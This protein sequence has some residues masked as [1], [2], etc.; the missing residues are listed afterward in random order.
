M[1]TS[2]HILI[3]DDD[4]SVCWSLARFLDEFG[5]NI[6]AVESAEEGL[7]LMEDNSFDAGVIDLRL[8][9]ISGDAF[10]IEAHKKVP[11]MRFLIHTGSSDYELS[12]ELIDIGIRKEDVFI[13][14]LLDL[15][16][17]REALEKIIAEDLPH[18]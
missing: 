11:A 1:D 17:I 7:L 14:P 5:F 4:T 2:H 10:I 9:G 6:T 8:P 13:K 18:D 12:Q 15:N 16:V 3:I